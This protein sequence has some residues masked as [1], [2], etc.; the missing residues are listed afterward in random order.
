MT[1]SRFASLLALAAAALSLLSACNENSYRI[2][3]TAADFDGVA[4]LSWTDLQGGHGCDSTAVKDGK[5]RFRGTIDDAYNGMIKLISEEAGDVR[6]PLV[7]EPGKIR[8]T[9][10]PEQVNE[11]GFCVA[12]VSGTRNNDFLTALDEATKLVGKTSD[13]KAVVEAMKEC[14]S[15][16]KDCEY[17]AFLYG[18]YCADQPLDEYI[19]GFESFSDKAQNS[20]LASQFRRT[21]E[22]RKAT[23][24]GTDAPDFTLK[25]IDGQEVT[26]SSFRGRYVIVD[27]WASWCGPCRRG[28]PAMKELYA[29]YRDKGLE[30]IAVSQD[31]DAG[32]WQK[33]VQED[34]SEWIH[35]IVELKEDGKAMRVGSS[36]GVSSIPAYFLIDKEGR[37]VGKF[38]HD[39]L[40][41]QLEKLLQP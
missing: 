9:M 21:I 25:S 29:E 32:R 13:G 35:L 18:A 10:H 7:L 37:F 15:Q 16:H 41:E 27:F 40:S 1:R 36:Y 34:Q 38:D 17:A 14:I 5:F 30:I 22:S 39:G 24:A 4:M 11:S 28:V 20:K 2:D 19:A 26:L 23:A 31:D 6:A 33:A 8:V 12:E 3:G